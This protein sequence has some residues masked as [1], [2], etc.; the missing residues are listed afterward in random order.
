MNQSF[1]ARRRLRV[2]AIVVGLAVLLHMILVPA[3][4]AT[5]TDSF[6]SAYDL[7]PALSIAPFTFSDSAA[8]VSTFTRD[9]VETDG[10]SACGSY[11]A[12]PANTYSV[13]YTFTAPS[14]GWLTLQ[15][16]N[17]STNY[18]TVIEVWKNSPALANS[19][20]CNDDA[21]A[22]NRRSELTLQVAAG[23]TYLISVRRHGTATMA[24]PT[25]AFDASFSASRQFFVDQTSGSDANTGS[26]AQ[27]FRT[28]GRAEAMLPA[29]GGIISILDPGIYSEAVTIDVP[30]DLRSSAS[31]TITSVT[32]TA[33]PV[34]ATSVSAGTVTVQPGA[35]VQDGADLAETGGWLWLANG[36]YTETVTIARDMT[37]QAQNEGAPTLAAPG[38][39]AL[40]LSGGTVTVKGLNIH[41]ATGVVVTGGTGHTV[42]R[43]NIA[44]NSS[45]TGLDNQ[46]A[47]QVAA[48]SNW[49]GSA[50]GPPGAGD[51]AT[52]KVTFRP[53]CDTPLPTC[54]NTLGAATRL[55]FTSSPGTTR[56]N[57]AFANQP[58]VRATDDLGALDPT[59]TGA[60]TI[61]IKGG[62]GT[63]GAALAG[64]VTMNAVGGIADFAGTNLAID[65][66]GVSYQ[67]SASSGG[68]NSTATNDSAQFT[69]TADR[70]IVTASPANP[71]T[72]GA[73]LAVT[74][75][76]Q[77]GAGHTDSTFTGN[78]TLAI[79]TNPTSATLA[80]TSSKAAA[81]GTASFGGAGEASIARPGTGY[82]LRASSGTL[83]TDDSQP[84]DIVSG[85]ATKLVFSS[86][87]SDSTAGVAFTTQPSV[88]VQDAVGNIVTTYSGNVTLAIGTNP[89]GGTLAG[90]T[91]VAV[92]N[93]V[94]A[95]TGLNIDKSGTGYTL[96]ASSTG[97]TGGTST[98]F[99]IS[100]AAAATL[101]FVATPGNT[102]AAAAFTN[103][104]V[105]E[106][107]DAFGNRATSFS[108]AVT[109]AIKPG[110]GTVG[111]ALGGTTTVNASNGV[112][113]FSGL[114]IDRIGAAYQLSAS[115]GG[116]TG[117]DSGAFNITANGLAFTL[118]P[119]DTVA[120]QPILVKVA[121][122]DGQGNTDTSFTGNVT[123]VLK[124]AGRG[125]PG[126]FGTTTVAA[127]AG[128]ADFT[129]ANVNI[130]TVGTGYILTASTTSLADADSSA[131]AILPGAASK[132]VF[133][134]QPA[135]PR[136]DAVFTA[137]VQAQD[138]FGNLDT[139]FAGAV[140]LALHTNP[141]GG[142]LGGTT[143]AAAS[144]G[145]ANFPFAASLAIDRVGVGYVLR[146]TS[147]ALTPGDSAP[148]N[149]TAN[150]L[151]FASEPADTAVGNAFYPAPVVQAVDRFGTVDTT[152]AGTI[153]LAIKAGTGTAGASLRGAYALAAQAGSANFSSISI[154]RLGTGYQLI[155]AA[156]GLPAITSAAFN[157]TRA[158]AYAPLAIEPPR[159]DLIG[160]F[161][162]S[163]PHP[164][165]LEPVLIT[166]TITNTGDAPSTEFW[167]DFY[168]NPQSPPT[169]ANQPWDKQCGSRRCRYGI[170]W[171]VAQPLAPGQSI[172]LTSTRSSYYARNTDW[173]GSFNTSRLNLYMYVD[174]WNPTISYGA[175]Y[176]R[177]EDNNRSEMHLDG[178][179]GA[180]GTT[181]LR[182]L[183]PR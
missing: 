21:I 61:A 84:F 122:Q 169:A 88:E 151:L 56:T 126:L 87:P 131:F 128:V 29:A 27:P 145:V 115:A 183:P 141:G 144:G 108:G 148:F 121:A 30:T 83:A 107:Q 165:G 140:N 156:N 36:T 102:R 4:Y 35:K 73:P 82:T 133:T 105:V 66:V 44:G 3:A 91:T 146:A 177:H 173:P 19:A 6:G 18:D 64:T 137:T 150:R 116:L 80:G 89:G 2:P 48:T 127:V 98:S 14:A 41:G 12:N 60:V 9:A 5:V 33:T 10:L 57:A 32:L 129:S 55:Q 39:T 171:L 71:T 155:A 24:S 26:Q 109:L 13:W 11:P 99:T 113:S 149:V 114:S 168:I 52:G 51:D 152:F 100:P 68:L 76:A 147:G 1:G 170:A 154:D 15:T 106:A 163:K 182:A 72:A 179:A 94:A 74:V 123:L 112:A 81:G 164:A 46:T 181:A 16:M 38:G 175:V 78:I 134:T 42:T 17:A 63:A 43:N 172:T 101:A 92:S 59:F 7:T 90:T 20:G 167:V 176:E 67:L 86:S 85:A 28:V 22:G 104:P 120:G 77:D 130:R 25:L 65:Y 125:G 174:S 70:L 157:I 49:W 23:S 79:Q 93:G 158:L 111:A 142:T 132:L 62:T 45:G 117:A 143:G 160:S 124:N 31:T 103:Q 53:W 54:S 34:S 119:A 166:A 40:T 138:P 153:A 159:A 96:A 50:A 47:T 110:T 135:S 37:V 118:Q 161:A 69:I 75:A 8:S 139:T 180:P 58:V 136:A 95:F 162:L 178:A 97:L